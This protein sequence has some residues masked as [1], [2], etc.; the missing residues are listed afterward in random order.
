LSRADTTAFEALLATRNVVDYADF[1][2]PYLTA[3]AR[4][5]DVGCGEGT[6]TL[7]LAEKASQVVGVDSDGDFADARRHASEHGLQNVEFR[8]GSVYALELPPDYFDARLA[9]SVLTGF[10]DVSA[11]SRF[12][13]YGTRAAVGEFS[14]ARAEDCG[15]G[16]CSRRAQE[17]G[18]ATA[19]E[20]EAMRRAWV[21]WSESPE[22]S[23]AFAWCRGVGR[24][25]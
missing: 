17:R 24:T 9:H 23:L 6:I 7:G 4:V 2:L 21:E 1:L 20:L 8:C 16:W 14:L 15:E 22:A 18:L 10:E 19:E 25:P 3:D 5:L 11:T 12:F 13:S